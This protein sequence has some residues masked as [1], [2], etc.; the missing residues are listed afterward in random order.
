MR[1][2]SDLKLE[3]YALGELPPA[4]RHAIETRLRTDPALRE[5]LSALESSNAAILRETPP[6]AFA[7]R[8]QAR[9][10]RLAAEASVT[11]PS[12]SFGA[13]KP[14]LGSLALVLPLLAI[15]ALPTAIHSPRSVSETPAPSSPV[16]DGTEGAGADHAMETTPQAPAHSPAAPASETSPD[17]ASATPPDDGIRLKGLEP[18]LAIFRK[19]NNGSEP[20]HPGEKARAGELLRIGYQAGGFPYGAILSVDGNGNVTRHWPASG[21]RAGRLENGEALLPSSF[22]LDEAPDFERFYFVVSKRPFALDPLLKSLREN[23]TLPDV[24]NIRAI[25]ESEA[26]IVRFEILKETG[27]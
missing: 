14:V 9:R 4:E 1:D 2:I 6:E 20:L 19:T 16:P 26:R 11:R 10:R 15:L 23:E 13:W 25:R 18:H 24:K 3:R 8:L 5:R 12:R 27:I 7:A 17:L 22:E 21:E